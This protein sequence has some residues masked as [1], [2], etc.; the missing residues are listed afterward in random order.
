MP[1]STL[2]TLA[3]I[4][5]KVRRL[6]RSPSTSQITNAD[7]DNYINTFI[8]YDFPEQLRLVTLRKVFTFYAQ[9]YID[10]YNTNT[11]NP[12]DP[13]FNFKNQYISVHPPVYVAGNSVFYSQSREQF[14]GVYPKVNQISLIGTGD[15]LTVN[16]AGTLPNIPVL[17]NQVTLTSIDANNNGITLRDSPLSA[18]QGSMI[19]VSTG[20]VQGFI[21]YITGFY[22]ILL[23]IAPASGVEVNMQYLPYV[24]SRPMAMLFY[25]DYLVLRPV[26]DQPYRVDMECY[27]RPTEMLLTTQMNE[28]SEWWQYIAYG[29]SK[30]IFEDRMDQESVQ[31]IMPEFK[32]Q[33]ALILRR[34]IV[35]MS[36]DRV[37]TIYSEQTSFGPGGSGFGFG[38]P[39]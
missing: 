16:F 13:F 31:L 29:A 24:P 19:D 38:G 15:G 34:S 26:P 36:N 8:L 18:S 7:I 25:E 2:S 1:D 3:N 21:N 9:P 27:M 5:T 12:N 14:Y 23:A 32:K 22:N 10:T 37:S 4:R 11:T 33:E 6:T 35:Q 17:Q 28:L 39:V 20:L 30:K